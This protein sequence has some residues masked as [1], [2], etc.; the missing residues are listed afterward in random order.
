[1]ISFMVFSDS[2]VSSA[3]NTRFCASGKS[4]R[5]RSTVPVVSSAMLMAVEFG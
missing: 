2:E 1:M 5:P 4:F 3:T